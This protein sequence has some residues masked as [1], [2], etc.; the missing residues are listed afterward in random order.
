MELAAS[1]LQKSKNLHKIFH[2]FRWGH[3]SIVKY[4]LSPLRLGASPMMLATATDDF[5]KEGDNVAKVEG[6]LEMQN[7][8]KMEIWKFIGI[9]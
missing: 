4:E 7:L 3:P 2:H 6:L 9:C 1:W 5:P 8:K